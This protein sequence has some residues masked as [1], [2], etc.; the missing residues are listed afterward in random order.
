M[1][2]KRELKFLS[3]LFFVFGG[4]FLILL[5]VGSLVFYR[6]NLLSKMEIFFFM[7][8]GIVLILLGFIFNPNK[9]RE[10]YE[11]EY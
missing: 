2:S 11:Y 7:V 10:N 6:Y 9:T 5:F 3:I 8:L 4:L 1:L